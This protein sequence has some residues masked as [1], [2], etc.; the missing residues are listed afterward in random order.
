MN[1]KFNDKVL[2]NY[3]VVTVDINTTIK[4]ISKG[5]RDQ[6]VRLGTFDSN[7]FDLLKNIM[8]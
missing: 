8:K 3:L 4:R 6:H 1:G 5:Q 7:Y 2:F